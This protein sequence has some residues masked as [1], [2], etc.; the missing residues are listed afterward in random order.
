MINRGN[1]RKH[2][3][4]GPNSI[5][6]ALSPCKRQDTGP[7]GFYHPQRLRFCFLI[8]T[9]LE[10][11]QQCEASLFWPTEDAQ[12]SASKES[13]VNPEAEMLNIKPALPCWLEL[14]QS[15]ALRRAGSSQSRC[16]Q[17][18]QRF[19][20]LPTLAVTEF[21]PCR[22]AAISPLPKVTVPWACLLQ[23]YA[24]CQPLP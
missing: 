17:G 11:C 24:R 22:H 2:L 4:L 6:A 19:D 20:S 15:P 8:F 18:S 16:W 13:S 10:Q 5:N 21:A 9:N 14:A 12:E 23:N 1:A 3:G 7:A